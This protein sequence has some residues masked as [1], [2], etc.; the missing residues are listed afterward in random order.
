M[1]LR[2]PFGYVNYEVP[3]AEEYCRQCPF[4]LDSLG[5]LDKDDPYWKDHPDNECVCKG[6]PRQQQCKKDG[7]QQDILVCFELNQERFNWER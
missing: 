7:P 6:C 2:S 1:G 3:L 4:F 5:Y